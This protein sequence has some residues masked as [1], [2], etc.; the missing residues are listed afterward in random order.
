MTN[1]G[2]KALV[3]IECGTMIKDYIMVKEN[4]KNNNIVYCF[5]GVIIVILIILITYLCHSATIFKES[6]GK[7]VNEHVNHVMKIDSIFYDMKT[8]ILSNDTGTIVNSLALLSQLQCDSALFR[9]EVQLSQEEMSNLVA[10]HIEK[11][12]NDYAQIGIWGGVLSVI[13]IIFGFFAIFKIEE[14]KAD[15]KDVLSNVKKQGLNASIEI[16]KLQDQATNL[17]NYLATIKQ[18]S[19]S[20]ISNKTEEFNTLIQDIVKMHDES[21]KY[22]ERISDLLK[23][24][25]TKNSQYQWSVEA[26]STQMKQLEALT[27]ALNNFLTEKKEGGIS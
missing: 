26:M 6:Q 5:C 1:C 8:M 18:N 24:V 11:I 3:Q 2:K 19:D 17:N 27:D 15:A 12:E 21:T 4:R 16:T 13:F 14:T 25:E 23:E 20:F 22:I 9:R 10:L 7:I